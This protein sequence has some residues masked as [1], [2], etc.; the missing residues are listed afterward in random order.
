M[1]PDPNLEDA[2]RDARAL[3]RAVN[4]ND[5]DARTRAGEVLGAQLER[6]FVYADALH[7]VARELGRDSW[8]ALVAE[9]RR[10]PIR[11]ALDA[12]LA[13]D[14]SD[15][16]DVDTGL[17]YPDGTPVL[18]SV[19]RREHR[20]LLDDGGATVAMAGR[21]SGWLDAAERA[22]RRSGMNVARTTGALFVPAVEGRDLERLTTRLAEAAL[23]VYEAIVELD[24]PR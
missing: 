10:G 22:V 18:V 1:A 11:T 16:V 2:R 15:A 7:V 12:A 4:A 5:R 8:P 21:R 17:A 9:R 24:E 3:L 19:R 23:Y 14:A 20:Y 6:R 13:E